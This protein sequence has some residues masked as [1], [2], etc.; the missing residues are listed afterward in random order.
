MFESGFAPTLFYLSYGGVVLTSSFLDKNDS[1]N[2]EDLFQDIRVI[3]ENL[4]YE[5]VHVA[6]VTDC[7][8]QVIRVFIDSLG[9]I[10]VRDCEGVSRA[11]NRYLDGQNAPELD[12]RYYL[13]VSSPGLER[14]LFNAKDYERFKGKEVRVKTHRPLDGKKLHQGI[15]GASNETSVVLVTE[16]GEHVVPFDDIAR[17]SLVFRGLEPQAPKKI[18][19]QT[20]KKS[21]KEL[22]KNHEEEH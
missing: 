6:L 20:K 9:G 19:D 1:I 21:R 17:A 3:V 18:K 10:N 14:P 7:G 22:E 15:I 16:R 4:G 12:D 2:K 8:Q 13:E 5:C 11:L